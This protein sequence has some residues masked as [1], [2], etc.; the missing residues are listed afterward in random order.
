MRV[1]ITDTSFASFGDM[2]GGLIEVIESC[3][4]DGA[5][6][7]S[8]E[9]GVPPDK[10]LLFKGGYITVTGMGIARITWARRGKLRSP[11]VHMP[12]EPRLLRRHWWKGVL[13]DKVGG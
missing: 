8:F 4:A 5:V 2:D 9:I 3:T 6:S 13:V 7:G 12:F 10:Q 1:G 11:R